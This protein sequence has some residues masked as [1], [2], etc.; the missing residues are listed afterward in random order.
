MQ[1]QSPSQCVGSNAAG[2]REGRTAVD[3]MKRVLDVG[4]ALVDGAFRGSARLTQRWR[5]GAIRDRTLPMTDHV[6]MT[7]YGAR[8]EIAWRDGSR[9]ESAITR[10]GTVTLIPSGHEARWDVGGP[11]EVSHVYLPDAH[12]QA[13]ADACGSRVGAIQLA[14]R[15]AFDDAISSRLLEVLALEARCPGTGSALF[16]DQAIDLLGLQ[17]LRAH[18]SN[19]A[20]AAPGAPRGLPSWKVRR[21]TEYLKEHLDQDVRLEDLANAV[22]LSRFHFCTA[23]RQATGLAPHRWL[24]ELR[25]S[26]ARELLADTRLPVVQVALAVGYQAPSAFAAAFRKFAGVTPTEF[27]RG[28]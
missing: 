22:G 19:G 11:I 20:T 25:M 23:F 4:P 10:P 9:R 17:L 15:I 8:Q 3:E 7:Y 13:C 14:D 1:E 2:T 27:R 5:H 26:R 16:I 6:I 28:L 12:L 18:A 21:V 24:I